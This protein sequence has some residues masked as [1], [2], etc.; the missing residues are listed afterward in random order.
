VREPGVSDPDAG[1]PYQLVWLAPTQS[2][3]LPVAFELK[4]LPIPE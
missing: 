3:D 4:D 2:K 1:E